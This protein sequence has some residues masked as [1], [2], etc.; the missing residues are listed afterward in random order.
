M[1]G[2]YRSTRHRRANLSQHFLRKDRATKLIQATSISNTDFVIEIGAGRG[3]LTKP[4]AERA[5]KLLAIEVDLF[6]AN[7][8]AKEFGDS[9]EVLSRDFLNFDLPQYEYKVIGNI[10]Y[11]ISTEI[12]RKLVLAVTP[13]IDSWLIV[14]KDL[15]HRFCGRPYQNESL[16]SLRVKPAFHIEVIDRLQRRDFQPAPSVDSVF[17]RISKRTRQL[18]TTDEFDLYLKIII[19]A[20]TNANTLR[21]ALKPWLSKV[22]LRR[23]S[24]DLCFTIDATP[25][26]L[27]FE[28]WLGILRFIQIS[29]TSGK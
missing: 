18:L 13:P 2:R 4:L 21:Q 1:S 23:L 11:A 24:N 20:F 6:L 28:Q 9:V 3:A 10:P 29:Q 22:Q 26:L 7:K 19:A 12:I 25:S 16:W 14:Q 8:L 17:V 5:K 27:A 15:A